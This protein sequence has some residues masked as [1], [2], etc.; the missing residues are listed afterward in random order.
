MLGGQNAY[1]DFGENSWLAERPDGQLENAGGEDD[2]G[3]LN[4]E[5]REG[6]IIGHLTPPYSSH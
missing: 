2:E 1:Y 6:E 3:E 4:E 5:E